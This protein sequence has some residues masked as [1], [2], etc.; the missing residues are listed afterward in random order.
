MQRFSTT[1][2]LIALTVAL[3][4]GLGAAGPGMCST[5]GDSAMPETHDH[6]R[7]LCTAPCHVAKTPPQTIQSF[8]S[9]TDRR[10]VGLDGPALLPAS[11]QSAQPPLQH[12]TTLDRRRDALPHLYPVRLHLLHAVFLN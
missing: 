3:V 12:H 5:H 10:P 4:F 9:T 6:S 7:D 1:Y 8:Q 2:R 11:V